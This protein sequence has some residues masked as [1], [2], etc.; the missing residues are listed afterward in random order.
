MQIT[1]TIQV[2]SY[3][4]LS[5]IMC[6]LSK[7]KKKWD[8]KFI[9]DTSKI[10]RFACE[11]EEIYK[12]LKLPF[13]SYEARRS[14][15]YSTDHFVDKQ[16]KDEHGNVTYESHSDGYHEDCDY[17]EKP[18]YKLIKRVS[19]YPNGEEEVELFFPYK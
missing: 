18:P 9:N 12:I 10:I 4:Q 15:Y 5:A 19:H 11:Y 13:K 3:D 8:I 2:S 14:G 1:A 16:I 17:T 7:F 6:A